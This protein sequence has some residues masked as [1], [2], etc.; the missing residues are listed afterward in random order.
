MSISFTSYKFTEIKRAVLFA[1]NCPD[2][3]HISAFV[4]WCYLTKSVSRESPYFAIIAENREFV[5]AGFCQAAV[6]DAPPPTAPPVGAD[7]ISAR[8][9]VRCVP[10]SVVPAAGQGAYTMRPYGRRR[11]WVRLA[12]YARRLRNR[13]VTAKKRARYRL[14]TAPVEEPK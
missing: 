1:Q 4:S 12:H 14:M 2:G 3:R 10:A 13:K 5:K 8:N 6:S 11:G 7:Y 9:R